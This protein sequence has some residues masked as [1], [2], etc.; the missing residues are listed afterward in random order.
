[1]TTSNAP[2]VFLED[3]ETTYVFGLYHVEDLLDQLS[4]YTKPTIQRDETLQGFIQQ[5]QEIEE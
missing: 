2:N 1:M 5:L 3:Y 4:E